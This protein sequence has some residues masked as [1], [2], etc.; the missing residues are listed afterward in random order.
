MEKRFSLLLA[1]TFVVA[2]AGAGSAQT[3]DISQGGADQI[4]QGTAAGSRAGFSLDQ[5][6]VSGG[7]GRPDLIVGAPGGPGVS[8]AVYVLFGGPVRDG[9]FPL[10]SSDVVLTGAAAG[11]LFG[12]ATAA[13]N[14]FNAEGATPRN[15]AVGAPNALGG[16]GAVYVFNAGFSNGASAGAASARLQVLGAPGDQLGT[17]LATADLDNDGHREVI[18]GAPGNGRVYIIRGG[19]GLTGTIDLSV[20]AADRTLS[21]TGIGSVLAAG[22]LTGD[23]IY[24]LVVG[25][26]A[27]NL[28]YLFAGATGV[29]PAMA[30][31]TYAGGDAGDEAGAS[32]RILDMD[33]DGQRDLVVGAPGGDG[34]DGSRTNAGEAHVLWGGSGLLASR[35][36]SGT[37][38][39]TI[40]GGAANMRMASMLAGGDINRDTPNDLVLLA[41]G[42]AGG[43]QMY[44]YYGRGRTQMGPV[45]G[46][47][48]LLDFATVSPSR[49]ILGDNAAGPMETG[50]V[51]EVTGEGARDL[52][53]GVPSADSSAGS[54][55]FT[56][57]P[58]LSLSRNSYSASTIQG[59]TTTTSV[60]VTNTSTINVP[61]SVSSNRDW[62]AATPAS[63]TSNAS[64]AGTFTIRAAASMA[65]GVYTGTLTVTSLTEDLRM[66]VTVDVTLTVLPSPPPPGETGSDSQPAETPA[67]LDADGRLDLVWQNRSTGELAGWNMDGTTLFDSAWLSPN[68]VDPA[69]KVRA[70]AD[71]NRDGKT[72]LVWQHT[73]GWIAVWFMDNTTVQDTRLL[74]IPQVTD[75][76]WLVVGAADMNNDLRADIVWQNTATGD[77]AVWLMWDNQVLDTRMVARVDPNWKL[78]ATGDLSRDDRADFIFQHTDGTLAVWFMAGLT[79]SDT[80]IIRNVGD[81]SWKV[82]GVRDMNND[83]RGDLI[84][85]HETG[86]WIATWFMWDNAVLDTRWLTPNQISNLDWRIVG[87][88]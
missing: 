54:V 50:Q 25:R 53:V 67:A 24:D 75:P 61:W 19:I 15:L 80:R 73:D 39:V 13:G 56:T 22:E 38:D 59:Q 35:D 78:A 6:A 32:L 62:L 14:I 74:S 20:T 10:S 71:F 17:A 4:W 63:G 40:Y 11:D 42:A 12:Y 3:I 82:R 7:D 31:A 84:F 79:V 70:T 77:V 37:A 28:V 57:S 76:N 8:G 27:A 29:L 9:T 36:L 30:T 41:P 55:Y 49:I 34:P 21:G 88:H 85:Q 66:S 81:T 65:P 5:G 58:K 33:S 87:S 26:P 16:R 52:V 43:G 18:M 46:G 72:D 45:V 48:R 64:A 69:W 2:A 51:F 83:L 86:G 23:S 44:I 47:R 1:I 60:T 68:V